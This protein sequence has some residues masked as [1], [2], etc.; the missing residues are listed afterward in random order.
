MFQ[1]QKY[2]VTIKVCSIVPWSIFVH[3][4]EIIKQIFLLTFF[5]LHIFNNEYKNKSNKTYNRN[6]YCC[7]KKKT[8]RVTD[9]G[10][11]RKLKR[12]KKLTNFFKYFIISNKYIAKLAI[13]FLTIKKCFFSLFSQFFRL[14]TKKY[15]QYFKTIL[16]I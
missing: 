6:R 7:I 5:F 9:P 10:L 15:H 1:Q 11:R 2:Q 13:I 3:F 12:Q 16:K 14:N 8:L 4:P